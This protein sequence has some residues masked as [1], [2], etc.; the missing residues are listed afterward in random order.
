MLTIILFL[1]VFN[2]TANVCQ[3]NLTYSKFT[4][5]DLLHINE[6]YCSRCMLTKPYYLVDEREKIIIIQNIKNNYY[7]KYK[8]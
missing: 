6:N 7:S 5:Y 4:E 1:N 8:K 3:W 2:E